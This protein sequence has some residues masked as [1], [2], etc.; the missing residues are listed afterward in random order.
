M[1]YLY[2][3]TNKL[4]GKIYIGQTIDDKNRW[5]AHKSYAKHRPIQ[6]IHQAMK[7]YGIE[8]FAYEVIATCRTPEDANE[9]EIV[10]I[11]QY[12]SR[13]KEYGY[14][15]APG[16]ET[17]WNL[18]LPKDQNP[19]TGI[20][21]SKE[22]RRKISEGNM[23]KIM[24][25]ATDE[26]KQKMSD[27]YSGR[28]LPRDWVEKIAA[29]N[30]GKIRSAETIQKLSDSH[31]GKTGENSSNKKV[32]WA[33]VDSIRK[34]YAEGNMSQAKLAEKYGVTSATIWSI[35]NYKSWIR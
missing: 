5:I 23:G 27:M 13:N 14:N 25:P 6:Y 22:T 28:T 11:K 16:G 2:R 15:L 35:V 1:H 12:D 33:I 20:P 21:R 17:P 18:G 19:L 30:S 9:T 3:I 8:N 7:K 31:I 24:P 29:S 26:R 32:N 34:E 10:L 4:S